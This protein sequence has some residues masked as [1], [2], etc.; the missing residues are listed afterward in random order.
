MDPR[1]TLD[2]GRR[3]NPAL[4]LAIADKM[5][6][7]LEASVKID[8][9]ELTINEDTTRECIAALRAGG[10]GPAPE[11]HTHGKHNPRRNCVLCATPAEA[12]IRQAMEAVEAAGCDERLTA[13]VVLLGQAKDRVA[14]FVE[15]ALCPN[16]GKPG[17]HFVPPS[18]GEPGFYICEPAPEVDHG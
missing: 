11:A 10:L 7:E 6:R 3:S 17:P 15:A 12:A 9:G 4:W 5:E 13:A 14:D 16:C 2:P 1:R 18:L 8:A